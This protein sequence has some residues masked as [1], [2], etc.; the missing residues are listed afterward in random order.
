MNRSRPEI[1][2]F[3][4]ENQLLDSIVRRWQQLSH[5][6]VEK[7]GYFAVALS[8]GKTPVPLYRRL[9][10][11]TGMYLWGKTH[12]FLVDERFVPFSHPDSNGRMLQETLV[13]PLK[14]SSD[15][16]H[17]IPVGESTPRA[18]AKKYEEEIRGFFRLTGEEMPRFDLILL[19]LGEDGHTAS[20]FPENPEF[21][22]TRHLTAAIVLD[23]IRHSRITLTLPV[24]NQAQN[25]IFLITGRNK[26]AVAKRIIQERD[27]S[28]P[29]SQIAPQEGNLFFLL[30]REASSQ[31]SATSLRPGPK[32][33]G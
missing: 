14:I 5:G 23:E 28:L 19:G 18:A 1:Y 12:I 10:A 33:P 11:E 30:D 16:V 25:V 17:S 21:K 29:A 4:H 24:I 7:Q 31:L 20:L 32:E 6:A 27:A 13:S 8:G 3:D 26:A 22:E 15:N 9:A 2:V